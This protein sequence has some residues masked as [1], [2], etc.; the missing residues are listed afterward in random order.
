MNKKRDYVV[1]L[2]DML[3]SAIKGIQFIKGI[4]YKTFSKD[5]K[6]QF[7]LIRAIEVIGEVSKKIPKNLRILWC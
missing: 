1:Y 5:D 7:A 3:E 4:D 6:T 2:H